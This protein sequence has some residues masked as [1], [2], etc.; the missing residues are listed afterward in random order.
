M[1]LMINL[2]NVLAVLFLVLLE[3]VLSMDN[4]LV[5][6]MVVRHLP[7]PMQI[8]ALTYGIWGAFVFRFLALFCISFLVQFSY[9]KAVG[10]LYLVLVAI[11]GLFGKKDKK[12]EVPKAGRFWMTVLV[13]ELMDI[14]FSAD[15]I[16][17]AVS[18]SS[19]YVIVFIGGVLGICTM[20]IA[21]NVFIRLMEAFPRLEKT[22]MFLVLTFGMKLIIQGCQFD[23]VDFHDSHNPATWLFW[24]A[25]CLSFV[26]GLSKPKSQF[27][28]AFIEWTRKQKMT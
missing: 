20:R 11:S 24:G 18:V 28:M 16:L 14:S 6:A 19:N 9:L 5:L 2:T 7:K 1:F 27:E 23:G 13:V 26:F 4:A 8:R 12:V 22:A 21:A 15:S 25:V 10:G 17:A 3:G